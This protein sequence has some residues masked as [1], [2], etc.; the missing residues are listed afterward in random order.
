MK[1]Q[2][3]TKPEAMASTKNKAA[4][5]TWDEGDGDAAIMATLLRL[6]AWT[7]VS[8]PRISQ[9]SGLGILPRG[10]A[11]RYPLQACVLAYIAHLQQERINRPSKIKDEHLAERTKLVVEQRKAAE[12]AAEIKARKFCPIEET[13]HIVSE[14]YARTTENLKG[15]AGQVAPMCEGLPSEAIRVIIAERVNEILAM[16][17]EPEDIAEKTATMA[18][19]GEA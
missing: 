18:A 19:A 13:T 2:A 8:R 14:E 11:G 5:S 10:V 16:L 4:R 6:S 9:L 3:K 17:S 7:G 1:K 12:L 15:L